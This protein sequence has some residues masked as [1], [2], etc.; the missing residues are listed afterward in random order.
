LFCFGSNNEGQ[1][2]TGDNMSTN[3]PIEL[4]FFEN[5][6][7]KEITCQNSFTFAICGISILLKFSDK[8]VFSWGQNDRGQLGHENT[9]NKN[10]PTKVDFFDVPN[11]YR[12]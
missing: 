1:L 9:N 7:L 11:I 2:G 4:K 3:V 6:K 5:E 10:T 12:F 8:K